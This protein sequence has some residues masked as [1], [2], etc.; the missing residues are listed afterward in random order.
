MP[1]EALTTSSLKG[2][3]SRPKVIRITLKFGEAQL[4]NS[5]IPAHSPAR[6]INIPAL[7]Y[8]GWARRCAIRDHLVTGSIE[9]DHLTVKIDECTQSEITVIQKPRN[10]DRALK[11]AFNECGRRRY[12]K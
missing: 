5:S 6:D 4:N 9:D 3:R 11:E 10:L 12:L 2:V 8:R 7:N 1:P